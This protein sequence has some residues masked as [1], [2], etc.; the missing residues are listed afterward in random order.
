MDKRF[1][2]RWNSFHIKLLATYLLLT[3][4]GT[5][6][7][8]S[9][10][11]WSF[12]NYFMRSR[13]TDLENWTAA[14]N[15]SFAD[16]LEDNDIH[17]VALLTQRYG[18][19]ETIVLRVFNPQGQ[20]IASSNFK[21]DQLVANWLTVAGVKEAL[22]NQSMKGRTKGVLTTDDRLYI[23]RPILR[24]GQLLGVL[25]MSITLEQFQRQFVTVVW[26]IL[27]A[28]AITILL[29]ALV[30][31][32]FARSLSKPIERMRN[33]ANRIGGGHFSDRLLIRQSNELDQLANELNRMSAR[34]A[35]LD[36]ERRT[37]LPP[38]AN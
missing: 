18:A 1:S 8:T 17:R 6:M 27:G 33:F 23:A 12:N 30:S 34:L 22:Q 3:V 31:H 14:L 36:Q 9:Y 28:L 24:D 35:S 37:L 25:R 38:L 5:S 19:P 2:I 29:C 20:L 10:V 4:L 11:L 15:E 21:Q 13:Q 26:T 32:R 7:M 16:A